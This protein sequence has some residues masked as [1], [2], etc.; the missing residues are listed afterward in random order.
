M[1]ALFSAILIIQRQ[2]DP[3]ETIMIEDYKRVSA[4]N[5][6]VDAEVEFAVVD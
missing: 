5:E 1:G 3:K 4:G 2:T 6:E